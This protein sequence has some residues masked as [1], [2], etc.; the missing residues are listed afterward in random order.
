MV[1]FKQALFCFM[2]LG[3]SHRDSDRPFRLLPSCLSVL[4]KL[5]NNCAHNRL[6]TDVID[7]ETEFAPL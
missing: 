1:V 2:E 6:T 7:T 4:V 5:V 3:S